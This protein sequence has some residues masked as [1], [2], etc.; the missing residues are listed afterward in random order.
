MSKT[1]LIMEGG[2]MRCAYGAALLDRFLDDGISFDYVIGVSAG[3]G[4]LVSY[5]GGQRDRNFRF[6]SVHLD[7]PDYFGARTFLRNGSFFNLPHIY[8]DMI[9]H[10][11]VDPLNYPGI[12]SNPCELEM[13][14]TNAHHGTAEYLTKDDLAQDDYWALMASCAIPIVCKPIAHNGRMYYDG[15]VVDSIPVERAL[16][17]GCD[18]LVVLLS[19]GRD[20]K[21]SPQ[22]YRVLYHM[23]LHKYPQTAKALDKRHLLYEASRSKCF[24]LE[25]KGQAFLIMPSHDPGVTPYT[26][27]AGLLK[28]FYEIGLRDYEDLKEDLLR[29]LKSSL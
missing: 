21:M 19:R 3:A 26:K 14:T 1:G 29:F 7:D 28:E 2:G 15:G 8:H 23:L 17:K 11:G 10:D 13:V 9:V 24:D 27:D 25:E 12:A 22:K 20:Y 18:K 5:L 16:L 4:C 6:Y